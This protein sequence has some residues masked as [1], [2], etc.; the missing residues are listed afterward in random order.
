MVWAIT[1]E[2]SKKFKMASKMAIIFKEY[3]LCVR[4]SSEQ[5][6]IFRIG[7]GISVEQHTKRPGQSPWSFQEIQDGVQNG[8][9]LNRNISFMLEIAP[10]K[11]KFSLKP[12]KYGQSNILKVLKNPP[13]T[14]K[15]P[16]MA[17][18]MAAILKRH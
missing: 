8:R 5:A 12:R 6:E 15:K 10:N 16:M 1:L 4:I 2:L 9:H 11:L 3:Y 14:S 18:R 17:S 13:G 7:P